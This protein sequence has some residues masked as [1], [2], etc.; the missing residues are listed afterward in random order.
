MKS[1]WKEVYVK[2]LGKIVTGKTPKTSIAEN[3][4][5]EVPFLTPSDNMNVKYNIITKKTLTEKGKDSVKSVILPKN[6]VCVSCI[7]SD[8]G[9]VTITTRET[10]TNQQINS[11]IV[12][13][14]NYDVDFVYYLMLILGK[15]LNYHSK[16]STAVPIINKSTFSNYIVKCPD[17][18]LQKNISSILKVLDDKIEL[19]QQINDNLEQQAQAIFKSWFVD[20]EPFNRI[21]PEEWK[22]T[23]LDSITNLISRGITP[24]YGDNSEQMVINQKCIRNHNIDLSL[25]RTHTPKTVNEKWLKYGDLLINSTGTGT[26]GRVAQVWFEPKN[27]TVDSHVTIVRPANQDVLYYIGLW[28]IM[29]EKYIEA[30]HTGSTGQTELPR[31]R[32]K[33]IE[34]LCPDYDTLRQFNNIIEPMTKTIAVN[35][36]EN[37]RLEM[38]RDILLPKLMSGEIK[39]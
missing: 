23:T 37:K 5:G 19:N 27:L 16:T 35:Q 34:L 26:L 25:A 36:E 22:Q 20:F 39:V 6:A 7:G 15:Y 17:L 1:E 14:N 13:T 21:K 30:L 11:I 28:G 29:N 4:G 9:K 8:L 24:K 2:D 31:E 10:V 32:L 33:S 12:D 18:K 38:I 3:Y